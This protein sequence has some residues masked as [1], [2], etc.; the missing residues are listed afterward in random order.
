M[1]LLQQ[2]RDLS[3]EEA[4]LNRSDN[5]SNF[6]GT[7]TEVKQLGLFFKNQSNS[8][9]ERF[10]NEGIKWNFTSLNSPNITQNVWW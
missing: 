3:Q 5:G 1:N 2:L 7:N 9:T 4:N 8:L 10:H 6:V